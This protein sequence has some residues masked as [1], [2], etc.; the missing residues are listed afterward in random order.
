MNQEKEIKFG[1]KQYNVKTPFWIKTVGYILLAI[2]TSEGIHALMID[3]PKWYTS[4]VLASGVIAKFILTLFG[5][6]YAK[7][8]DQQDA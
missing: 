2:S 4:A 6:N 5:E 8:G 1:I 7:T 3:A